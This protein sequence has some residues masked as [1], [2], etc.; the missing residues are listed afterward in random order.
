MTETV[1]TESVSTESVSTE[2]VSTEVRDVEFPTPR[3]C[4]FAEPPEYGR[5]RERAPISKVQMPDGKAAW[6]VSRWAE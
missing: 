3:R 6:W 5:M 4:P 1:S 2:A